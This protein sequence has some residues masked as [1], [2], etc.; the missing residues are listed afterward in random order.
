MVNANPS[1]D[2]PNSPSVGIFTDLEFMEELRNQMLKF[3]MLQVKD[4][5][6][7]EDAVQEAMLSAYQNIDKFGRQAALKTWVFSILKNKLIDL[8]RKEKR[9]VVASQLEEGPNISGEALMDK[10]F[11]ENGH[12][13]K[14][15]RPQKWDDPDHGIEN[16]HFW[17]VFDAC[18]NALPEKYGRLFMMREFLEME[19]PEICHNEEI[20]VTSLNVTLYRARLRLRECLEDNWYQAKAS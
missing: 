7:A 12:W 14:H 3:A 1:S 16:E 15:E 4:A 18:L 11:S 6:L 5:Q 17:R 9:L 2:I 8:L 20:S 13:Q 10:L 19:T